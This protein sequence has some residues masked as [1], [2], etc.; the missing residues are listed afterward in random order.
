MCN[1]CLDIQNFYESTAD[2]HELNNYGSVDNILNF[3]NESKK[4]DLAIQAVINNHLKSLKETLAEFVDRDEVFR[5][6]TTETIQIIQNSC[7]YKEWL[8]FCYLIK[9]K[10]NRLNEEI[11]YLSP[12]P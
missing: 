4:I 5:K 3:F 11:K 2:F 7:Y 9:K 12:A 1:H 6:L 10:K 8:S